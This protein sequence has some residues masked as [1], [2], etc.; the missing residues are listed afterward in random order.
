MIATVLTSV[1]MI[2]LVSAKHL[3]IAPAKVNLAIV[4]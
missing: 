3:L 2:N 4:V 1:Q